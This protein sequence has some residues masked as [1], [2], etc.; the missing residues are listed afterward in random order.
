MKEN[1]ELMECIY[2][3]AEMSVYTLSC[4]TEDLK[5]KDNKIKKLLEDILKEYKEW[6]KK[7]AKY[8]EKGNKEPLNNGIMTKMMAKMGIKKEVISD[9]SDSSIA[10]MLIKGVST[11]SVDMEKRIKA[12]DKDVDKS[13]IK[14][15]EEF[16]RFQQKTIDR[17]KEYL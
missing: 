11:G 8:L 10:K 14:T 9:N 6:E 4:L 1:Y 12:Y 7:S 3:D 5:N 16:L 2:K 15:A 13:D 17:L